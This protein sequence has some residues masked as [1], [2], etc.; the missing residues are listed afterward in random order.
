MSAAT[1]LEM[2]LTIP[3]YLAMEQQSLEKHEYHDGE[4]YAMAGGTPRHAKLTLNISRLVGNALVGKPCSAY[5]SDLQVALTPK[6]FV[7]PD[8]TVVCDPPLFFEENTIAINNPTLIVE[9]LSPGTADYDRG[10]KFARYRQINSFKEYILISQDETN[11]ETWYK[12]D[13]NVWRINTF[14]TLDQSFE[15]TSLGVIISMRD[16]YDKVDFE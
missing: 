10:G 16:L 13:S 4:I 12:L 2:F 9:V 3:D 11:V 6:R 15:L 8:L 1:K 5:S 14:T 7:Y